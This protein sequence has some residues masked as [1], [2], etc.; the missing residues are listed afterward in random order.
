[1][2]NLT[3]EQ[4]ARLAELKAKPVLTAAEAGELKT[5]QALQ[6]KEDKEEAA[7]AKA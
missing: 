7:E 6:A 1:M 5:L 2:V 4:K 3:E